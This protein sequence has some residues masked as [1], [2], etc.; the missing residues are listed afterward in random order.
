MTTSASAIVATCED[1]D[2]LLAALNARDVGGARLAAV[3]RDLARA[4]LAAPAAVARWIALRAPHLAMKARLRVLVVGAER[5]DA[6]DRGR[7]YQWLPVLLGAPLDLSVALVGESLEEALATPALS[8]A[9]HQPARLHSGALASYLDR[10]APA[11][12]DLAIVF[13]PGFQKHRGWLRDSSLAALLAAGVPVVAAAYEQ[14]EAE[15]DRWVIECHGY[16]ARGEI[17]LNPF[18]LDLSDVG[19]SLFWGRALWQFGDRV[20]A[21]DEAVDDARL[22]RLEQLSHMVMHSIT[23]G[24][25][26]AAPHGAEVALEASDGSSRS[27]IYLFD[28]YFLV[29]GS[30]VVLAL[31]NGVLTQVASLPAEAVAHLPGSGASALERAVWAAE[32]KARYLMPFYSRAPDQAT[33]HTLARSMYSDLTRKVDALLGINPDAS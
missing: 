17:L 31:R 20:P 27:V 7:W 10:V 2:A 8:H 32:I 11:E 33:G 21:P 28:D 22:A 1:W 13:H 16:S 26:P 4:V 30:G 25:R 24:H 3:P 19:S 18:F 9:P 6:A 23:L 14:E 5:L 15:V 12:H 29:P